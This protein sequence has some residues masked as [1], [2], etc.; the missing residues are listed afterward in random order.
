MYALMQALGLVND[1]VE[2]CWARDAA[3][4]AREKFKVPHT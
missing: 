3:F 1:H 4:R 2:G